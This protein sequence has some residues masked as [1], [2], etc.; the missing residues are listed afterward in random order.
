MDGGTTFQSFARA[1][2]EYFA[3]RPYETEVF[4]LLML[5]TIL[6][7]LW[8]FF[9]WRP[10]RRRPRF[11]AKD[12]EF[13]QMACLQ[14]GLEE[15][16]QNLLLDL[17]EAF[18]VR[19]IYQL[20]LEKSIFHRVYERVAKERPASLPAKANPEYLSMLEEKLF[21]GSRQD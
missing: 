8:L 17:A 16:D 2:R 18:E 14:K 5:P 20:L 13:F 4:L 12:L 7:M 21:P 15:F 9:N 19:P 1:M 11:P 3:T 10:T 6:I